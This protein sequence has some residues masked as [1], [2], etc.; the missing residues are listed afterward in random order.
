MDSTSWAL[1]MC[2]KEDDRYE[3]MERIPG[4][5]INGSKKKHIPRE[6]RKID[7]VEKPTACTVVSVNTP[8]VS[9]PL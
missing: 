3:A 4:H 1:M 5:A 9:R 6:N 7:H 2:G 8:H